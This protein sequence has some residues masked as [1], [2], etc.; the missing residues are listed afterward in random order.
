MILKARPTCFN[1]VIKCFSC[2]VHQFCAE[3]VALELGAC[4]E[5]LGRVLSLFSYKLTEVLSQRT[6]T[7]TCG[8]LHGVTM[9]ILE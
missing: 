1:K 5:C 6:V 8:I 2:W 9:E 7:A 4:H 3:I